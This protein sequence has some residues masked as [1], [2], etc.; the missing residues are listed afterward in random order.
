M[1]K[2]DKILLSRALLTKA[3]AG[4]AAAAALTTARFW[5][6]RRTAPAMTFTRQERNAIS[7]PIRSILTTMTM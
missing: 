6:F 1:S 2:L 3:A 7:T 4:V 5:A